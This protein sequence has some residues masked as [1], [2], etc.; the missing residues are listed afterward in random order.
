MSDEYGWTP[1]RARARR[2]I[3]EFNKAETMSEPKIE[4]AT[5]EDL[6]IAE[7]ECGLAICRHGTV[8][9]EPRHL[10]SIIARLRA[11]EASLWVEQKAM[12]SAQKEFLALTERCE[13]A[14][15]ES[16]ER[17]K[18]L[19]KHGWQY[20]NGTHWCIGCGPDFSKTHKPSCPIAAAIKEAP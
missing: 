13:K 10:M 12:I 6:Q 5:D 4:P 19:E 17:R 3:E 1:A 15:A 20:T 16:E 11:A 8:V 14:E 7:G 2:I 18:R 9:V